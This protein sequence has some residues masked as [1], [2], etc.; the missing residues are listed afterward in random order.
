[1]R[2][3]IAEQCKEC[4]QYETEVCSGNKHYRHWES[5]PEFEEKE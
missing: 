3:G 1:M 4:E 2:L 5:C